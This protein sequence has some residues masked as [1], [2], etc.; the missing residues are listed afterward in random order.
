MKPKIIDIDIHR[1][2]ISGAPFY[3]VLFHDGDS[4]KIAIVFERK[5]YCAVL[6]ITKLCAGDIAFRSNSWRG[7]AF[8]SD[9]RE[10]IDNGT[11]R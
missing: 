10:F 6:D 7:D 2:G 8:E 4:R 1:N 3:A 5:G 9:L 11:R